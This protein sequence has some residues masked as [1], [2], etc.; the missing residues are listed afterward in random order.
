MSKQLKINSKYKKV[1]ITGLGRSGTS[2]IAAIFHHLGYFM[3]DA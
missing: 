3:P 1:L 2:A